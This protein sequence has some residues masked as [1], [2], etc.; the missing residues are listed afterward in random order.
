MSIAEAR[1]APA[2]R[3]F[4]SQHILWSLVILFIDWLTC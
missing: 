1:L 4:P 3:F 2:V